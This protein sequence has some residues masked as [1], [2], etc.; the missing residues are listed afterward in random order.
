MSTSMESG[1]TV[2]L[3]LVVASIYRAMISV[4][5]ASVASSVPAESPRATTQKTK[6][7]A[8]ERLCLKAV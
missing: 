8:I 4:V 3:L 6:K 5:D 7:N 2:D 1:F